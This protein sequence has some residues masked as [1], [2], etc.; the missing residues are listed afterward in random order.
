MTASTSHPAL[1]FTATDAAPAAIGPYSQ[2]VSALGLVF[3]SGQIPLDPVSGAIVPGDV[4]AQAERVLANLSAVL[5]ASG[6]SLSS[7]VKTTVF[8]ESM[9]DFAAMNAVYTHWFGDHKP[10]RSTF[11]VARLPRDAKVEIEAIAVRTAP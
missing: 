10:A 11:Q 1:S 4:T 7:V 3:C 8:L 5:K 2:A 6:A 9:A